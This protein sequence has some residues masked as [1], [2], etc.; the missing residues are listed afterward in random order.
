MSCRLF[1][2][3]IFFFIAFAGL[4]LA[5]HFDA[6][7]E[8]PIVDAAN[9]GDKF[10]VARLLKM[11][12]S[13]NTKGAFGTTALM[14]AAYLGDVE[15]AGMLINKGANV[16]DKDIGGA[17][18]LHIAAR[19]G[20]ST[21]VELLLKHGA[22]PDIKDKEGFD[23]TSRAAKSNYLK[24]ANK[25]Q[26]ENTALS[27]PVRPNSVNTQQ[28][29]PVAESDNQKLESVPDNHPEIVILPEPGHKIER[30]TLAPIEIH[31]P[32][33]VDK[34]AKHDTTVQD[35]RK[36][37]KLKVEEDDDNANLSWQQPAAVIQEPLSATI[38]EPEHI[39]PVDNS[40]ETTVMVHQPDEQITKVTE[41]IM[42]P[43]MPQHFIETPS[44]KTHEPALQPT[45]PVGLSVAEAVKLPD[46]IDLHKDF[47][48]IKRSYLQKPDWVN[49]DNSE[50]EVLWI[51]VTG[52][53]G[54][55]EAIDFWQ[56][57]TR[58]EYFQGSASQ[59]IVSKT[60]GVSAK[61][62]IGKFINANDAMQTCSVVRKQN[63]K[64]LCYLLQE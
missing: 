53:S 7:F 13:P 1:L 59:L 22:Q 10:E 56:D 64:L 12:I 45:V 28:N 58:D 37:V 55:Q 20:N 39:Q 49:P 46:D 57:L 3:V 54:K 62:R 63:S 42:L 50:L 23:P 40:R 25:M 15:L 36:Q 48:L 47:H 19:R 31:K 32:E 33:Q 16:N 38:I 18:A 17:T 2:Y 34:A 5:Q 29:K 41:P 27:Q 43:P 6:S 30:T 60:T 14:R 24:I 9:K 8:S 21:V 51:E 26:S 11:G 4:P 44:I 61:L 52:L 35:L